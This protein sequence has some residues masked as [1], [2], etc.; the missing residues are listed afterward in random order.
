[1]KRKQGEK[2]Y[3]KRNIWAF[4][5]MGC[6]LLGTVIPIPVLQSTAADF[7]A[8]GNPAEWVNV[9]RQ[10]SK[11]QAVPEWAVAQDENNL[12]FYAH[13]LRDPAKGHPAAWQYPY[14]TYANGDKG[15]SVRFRLNIDNNTGAIKLTDD[16][17]QDVPGATAGF[18]MNEDGTQ[19]DFE[20]SIPKSYLADSS[21]T[22]TYCGVTVAF[23]DI[24]YL[25]GGQ[26][27]GGNTED[28][29]Q[30]EGGNTGDGGQTEG[31]NTGDGGQTEGGSTSG[32]S[33]EDLHPVYEGIVI[34]GSFHDWDAV[35]KTD[36]NEG[37]DHNTVDQVA[38]VWDGD[39]IYLYFLAEGFVDENGVTVGDWGSVTGAGPHN[40]G[41]FVITTDL[42]RE[43]L[44]QLSRDNGGSVKGIDGAKAAV[45]NQE[46]MGAP[47]MWEVS[48]P[49]SAL[50]AYNETISFGL[51]QGDPLIKDMANF[52]ATSD[53]EDD[54][55][56][57]TG[58]F[59]GIV[60]DGL[61]GD[62]EYYPH[63]LIE[64]ATSGTQ[65]HVVDGE[66]AL[67]SDGTYL[68]AH[69]ETSMGAH[70]LEA[71][72]EFTS[73]VTIRLNGE[74]TFS[75]QYVAVDAQGN[76]NYDVQLKNLPDGQY[77]FYMIDAQGWK[78]AQNISELDPN[79]GVYGKMYVTVGPSSDEMEFKM[80]ISVMAAKFGMDAD[81]IK[82]MEA[83]FGR[84][85]QQWLITA[86]TSTGAWAGLLLCFGTVGV[87]AIYQG[88]KRKIA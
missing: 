10:A 68:Y 76:I 31:G 44:I 71:G 36:V 23:A 59:E 27:V 47:H 34:D 12:Y 38:M 8:D 54:S 57:T 75:P 30:T 21:Y 35:A 80:D 69:V 52:R 46:W 9:Q 39:Y 48:I 32:G 4:V 43:L 14:F 13:E 17:W 40:N 26:T 63:T 41:Q 74:H 55:Q 5:A 22:I 6:L 85:G 62:W 11:D 77:E 29:G 56:G 7:A 18:L 24:P 72:G 67:Y 1:M 2:R 19:G 50:P 45:N 87:T 25:S 73:A 33:Q 84:I 16:W 3:G 42:G 66:G 82:T 79:N 53:K 83:Q 86:G 78:T 28:G 51:Y 37:K 49:A 20:F 65:E 58:K 60:Y 70:L 15:K 64:Y 81:E 61:Y 88:R